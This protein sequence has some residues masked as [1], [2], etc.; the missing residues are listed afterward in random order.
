ML[1]VCPENLSIYW[2]EIAIHLARE[3]RLKGD[4]MRNFLFSFTFA[5]AVASSPVLAANECGALCQSEFYQTATADTVQKLLD[6]GA[7]VN[8]RDAAGKTPLHWVANADP[9]SILVLIAAGADV[10]ARDD[11]DRTP[12]HFVSAT[13]SAENVLL[14]LSAGAD[15]NAKTANDWTP[16]HGVAKFGSPDN[17]RILLEAGADASAANEMGE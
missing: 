15:V 1:S 16:L 5:M 7:D 4:I 17:V 11:L 14:L 3:Y 10:N 12:L 2:P 6:K 13:G 8:A 9:K